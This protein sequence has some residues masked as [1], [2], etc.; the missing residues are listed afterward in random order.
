MG[1]KGIRIGW[2]FTG[3]HCTIPALWPVLSE[4]VTTGAEVFPILSPAVLTTDTRFG[5]AAEIGTRLRE[6]C[7]HEP[8]TDL[9]SVEPIGSQ[10][11]LDVMVV[12]PCTGNTLAK[13]AHG[14][15]DTTVTF[16]CKA[17][18]R[19]QRPVVL[20]ISTNDGLSG[21]VTNLATLLRRKHYYFVPFGQDDPENKPNSLIAKMELLPATIEAAL[22]GRQL[23]PVLTGFPP[24]KGRDGEQN[25]GK[26]K[27][28]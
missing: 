16:A 4:I 26:M 27:E 17:H 20:A 5:R 11:L 7:G 1:L 10:R 23:Q 13:L 8:W 22:A 14:I 3:S 12:A 24:G 6:L 19:N 18:L 9:V 2:G 15:S 25:A 21:N 28:D